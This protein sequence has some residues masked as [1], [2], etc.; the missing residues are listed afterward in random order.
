MESGKV[1]AVVRA[2][3]NMEEISDWLTK[4]LVGAGLVD[5]KAVPG[6]VEAASKYVAASM[7]ISYSRPESALES[8]AASIII[9]FVVEGFIGG[10]LI[11]R[12]FFQIAFLRSDEIL[13]HTGT[14]QDEK[15][16]LSKGLQEPTVE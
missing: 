6:R 11:T 5:L 13:K 16:T 2:N 3:T 4:L 1:P 9:F 12:V 14:A 10:Y 8:I 15:A 7:T